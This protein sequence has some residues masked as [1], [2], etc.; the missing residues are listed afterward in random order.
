MKVPTSLR[1]NAIQSAKTKSSASTKQTDA[2]NSS[3]QDGEEKPSSSHHSE[4]KYE[5][6]KQDAS[7]CEQIDA[8]NVPEGEIVKE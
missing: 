8:V 2:N 6:D 3:Q 5:V 4:H 7:Q 1:R